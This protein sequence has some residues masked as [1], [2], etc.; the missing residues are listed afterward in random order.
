[1][2]RIISEKDSQKS[3][4]RKA[5]RGENIKKRLLAFLVT[6]FTLICMALPAYA[7]ETEA[8]TPS[9]RRLDVQLVQVSLRDSGNTVHQNNLYD[10]SSFFLNLTWNATETVHTGD[11]FDILVPESVDMSSDKLDRT[12]PIIDSDTGD[13]IGE[14]TLHPNGNEGGKISVVFN[15]QANNR[16]NLSGNIYL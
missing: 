4:I 10:G 2:I 9:P 16:S 14:G 8:T 1:M 3:K 12:F 6:V 11:Y 13:V 15:E 5:R 7:E